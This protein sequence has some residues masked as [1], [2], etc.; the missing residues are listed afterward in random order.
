MELAYRLATEDSPLVKQIRDN[1]I[2]SI[3]PAA[4]PDGRDRFVDWYY[5]HKINDTTEDSA[6]GGPPYWG[7]YIFHDNNRDIN[8]SQIT[9]RE[10]LEWYLKWHPPI[11]H[12]LHESVPFLYIYGAQPPH[13]AERRSDPYS[14]VPCVRQLRSE[15][16]RKV[17]HAGRVV[18]RLR[19]RVLARLRRL[20]GVQPQRPARFYE[21]FGNGG[22]NTM[23]RHID[24]GPSGVAFGN[25]AFTKPRVVPREPALQGSRVVAAQQHELHGDRR[26][27]RAAVRVELPEGAARELLSE[28]Q[29]LDRG[30]QDQRAVRLRHPRQPARHDGVDWMLGLL[31]QQGIE[32]GR[33][34]SEVKLKEGTFPPARSSSSAISRTGAWRRRCSRSRS[35]PIRSL[36]TYDDAAWTMGLMSHSEVKAR[37]RTRPSSTWR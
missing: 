31:R 23:L 20:H 19:R 37:S 11:I 26:P 27:D 13:Q 12:D 35:T 32:I 7:K 1:V 9:S 29:E 5:H 28:E 2:V 6:F 14:E 34:T 36:R 10:I 33:A 16:A 3:I 25:N 8:S 15:P 24:R 18:V 21:T 17:R 4:D 22:A 30:R